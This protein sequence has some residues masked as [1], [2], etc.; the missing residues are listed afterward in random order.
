MGLQP[1]VQ[2]LWKV[3]TTSLLVVLLREKLISS[4]QVLQSLRPG[5]CR[6]GGQRHLGQATWALTVAQPPWE[7]SGKTMAMK[8]TCPWDQGPDIGYLIQGLSFYTL[9]WAAPGRTPRPSQRVL[10]PS[11]GHSSI[12]AWGQWDTGQGSSPILFTPPAAGP[13]LC[14]WAKWLQRDHYLIYGGAF[15]RSRHSSEFM[16]ANR[17]I[18]S[19]LSRCILVLFNLPFYSTEVQECALEELSALQQSFSLDVQQDVAAVSSRTAG[20]VSQLAHPDT[21]RDWL[22][23]T[24]W[25]RTCYSSPKCPVS[26]KGR[27]SKKTL[28]LDLRSST[29]WSVPSWSSKRIALLTKSETLKRF[30]HFMC[31]MIL[32]QKWPRWDMWMWI[33][34]N[35][36]VLSSQAALKTTSLL[37]L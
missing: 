4:R 2:A 20:P 11:Q 29:R 1:P 12:P 35:L 5:R 25:K 37:S 17:R 30:T 3:I 21:L 23:N 14:S 13:G 18:I 6:A 24:N 16:C 8:H 7:G 26:S 31:E 22:F 36:S 10:T 9:F 33:F 32:Q 27:P 19:Q 15:S 34:P 28:G